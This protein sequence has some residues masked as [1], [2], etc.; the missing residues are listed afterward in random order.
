LV[1]F[2]LTFIIDCCHEIFVISQIFLPFF[3]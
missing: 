1:I 2:S 3:N